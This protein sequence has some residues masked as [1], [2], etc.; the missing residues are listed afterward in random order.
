MWKVEAYNGN[1][2][3]EV[4]NG[5]GW[6]FFA[7]FI[8]YEEALRMYDKKSCRDKC[9]IFIIVHDTK[10]HKFEWKQFSDVTLGDVKNGAMF[11]ALYEKDRLKCSYTGNYFQ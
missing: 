5:D 1:S 11:I 4:L 9:G 6:K 8:E 3:V 10:A 2:T 7:H